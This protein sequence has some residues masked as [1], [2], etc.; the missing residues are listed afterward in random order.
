MGSS[1][2][3]AHHSSTCC[4]VWKLV[5]FPTRP[6]QRVTLARPEWG[7]PTAFGSAARAEAVTRQMAADQ[8]AEAAASASAAAASTTEATASAA[9]A[10]T[11]AAVAAAPETIHAGAASTTA[12]AG[13]AKRARVAS[14]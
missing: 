7:R 12:G 2:H 8:R 9:A 13:T 3:G 5:F 4:Q 6:G 14:E 1:K 11:F 10:K